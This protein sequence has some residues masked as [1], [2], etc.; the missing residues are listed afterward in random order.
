MPV[1]IVAIGVDKR[2]TRISDTAVTDNVTKAC[3]AVDI[4]CESVQGYQ[5]VALTRESKCLPKN[6]DAVTETGQIIAQ[7]REQVK[8]LTGRQ[9]NVRREQRTLISP[10]SWIRRTLACWL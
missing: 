9:A 7:Q 6:D 2:V 5:L 4:P 10:R 1:I 3:S 8:I